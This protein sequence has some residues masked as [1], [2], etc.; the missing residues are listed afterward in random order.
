MQEEMSSEAS[1]L[2]VTGKLVKKKFFFENW[3]FRHFGR[4]LRSPQQFCNFF[5][6]NFLHVI[7]QEISTCFYE[8]EIVVENAIFTR[9]RNLFFLSYKQ[10]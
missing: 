2:C 8:T 7:E 10:R 1:D 4:F 5:W 3:K 6:I 9:W